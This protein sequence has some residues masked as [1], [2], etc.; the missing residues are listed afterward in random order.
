MG[1]YDTYGEQG[2]QLKCGCDPMDPKDYKVG[3]ETALCDGVYIGYEGVVVIDDGKVSRIFTS[4][5]DK[6][7]GEINPEK[8]IEDKNPVAQALTNMENKRLIKRIPIPKCD[9]CPVDQDS[10]MCERNTE[11][12]HAQLW[13]LIPDVLHVLGLELYKK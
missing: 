5:T 1:V 3:D 13:R 8:I 11:S 7:G 6:W 4:L 10:A 9:Q 2:I 12:C